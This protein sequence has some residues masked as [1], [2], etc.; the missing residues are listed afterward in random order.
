MVDDG[1]QVEICLH[2]NISLYFWF[3]LIST[4][5]ETK[6]RDSIRF[7]EYTPLFYNPCI[8]AIPLQIPAKP[9]GRCVEP[10]SLTPTAFS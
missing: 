4:T 8:T 1:G 5:C 9:R 6:G 10:M 7:V 2:E 3:L